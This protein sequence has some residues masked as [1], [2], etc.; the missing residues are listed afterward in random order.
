[1]LREVG[2]QTWI[3]QEQKDLAN[4]IFRFKD[5]ERPMAYVSLLV[6]SLHNTPRLRCWFKQDD[7]YFMPKLALRLKMRSIT[8]GQDPHQLVTAQLF[9]ELFMDALNEYAYAAELAHFNY[10]IKATKNSI[11]LT[12]IGFNDKLSILL[13][14]ILDKLVDFRV[15]PARFDILKEERLRSLS[16]FEAAQPHQHCQYLE[17]LVLS[18]NSCTKEELREATRG[19]SMA[20]FVW[21]QLTYWCRNYPR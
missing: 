7:E 8:N 11:S 10:E 20:C 17:N 5:T 16:N 13:H 14:K 15:E 12:V 6:N 3:F 19:I 1:M 2:P 4:I 21:L 18:E 9:V